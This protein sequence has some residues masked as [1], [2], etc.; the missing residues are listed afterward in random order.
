MRTGE[1]NGKPYLT[2]F[3]E[4]KP[5]K[6]DTMYKE[7]KS[8]CNARLFLDFDYLHIEWQSMRDKY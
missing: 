4:K 5:K 1:N 7:Q 3:R 6:Y 8:L 2:N